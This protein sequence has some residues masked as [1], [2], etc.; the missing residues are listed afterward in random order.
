MGEPAHIPGVKP[1]DIAG[2]TFLLEDEEGDKLRFTAVPHDT[3]EDEEWTIGNTTANETEA[4]KKPR[5]ICKNVNGGDCTKEERE[6]LMTHSDVCNHVHQEQSGLEEGEVHWT[7]RRI[8][9]HE[10]PLTHQNENHKGSV[11]DLLVEWETGEQTVEPLNLV[12]ADDP[13]TVAK[14]AKEH[15]MLDTEG[16][17]RLKRPAKREKALTRLVNQA[18]L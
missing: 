7:F 11:C 6:E 9:A 14:C 12:M 18:K 1:S 4:N 2:K 8:L 16:W 3:T 10:G 5:V 13:A 15:G 17:R